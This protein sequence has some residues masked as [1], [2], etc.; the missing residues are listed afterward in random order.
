VL[1]VAHGKGEVYERGQPIGFATLSQLTIGVQL[2][3]QTFSEVLLFDQ[4]PA[5]DAFKRGKMAFA[6]NASAV[7]VKAAASG[8]TNP[9]TV[10]AHAYS[11]GGMLL[12][13]SLGGQKFKYLPKDQADKLEKGKKRKNGEQAKGQATEE[14]A[15]GEAEGAH[16][17]QGEPEQPDS[18]GA[19][20][21]RGFETV[22]EASSRGFETVK[23]AGSRGVQVMK[24]AGS[25]VGGVVRRHGVAA[26]ALAL[27]LTGASAAVGVVRAV[28]RRHR[29][30]PS[31]A[32]GK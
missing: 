5:L 3:G 10:T 6:G 4:P 9:A 22:K 27:G 16:R 19:R 1:G 30:T 2:G 21:S 12:E 13:L 11:R 15:A 17:A 28:R 23:D 8:T 7:I 32:P 14:K 26:T 31:S 18:L 20:A 29:D 24:E 25:T